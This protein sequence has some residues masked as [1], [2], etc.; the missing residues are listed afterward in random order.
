[1]GKSFRDAEKWYRRGLWAVAF[2]FGLFLTGLAN[3]IMGDL[4]QVETQPELE[5]FIEPLALRAVKDDMRK[6]ELQVR[7]A[8]DT[9]EQAKLSHQV[10]KAD[11]DLAKEQFMAWV[12]ARQAGSQPEQ[13]KEMQVRTQ[14]VANLQAMERLALA[15]VEM[16]QKL[17]L[18][19]EQ[20]KRRAQ[21][22]YRELEKGARGAHQSAVNATELRVFLYRLLFCMPLLAAAA[23]L[24][25]HQL[26]GR[27][28]PLVWGFVGFAVFVFM[29]E[30]LPH[31]PSY[32]GYVHYTLAIGLTAWLGS[33]AMGA[34]N[35]YLAEK[36][37][38][39]Q[40]PEWERRRALD[41]DLA[42]TQLANGICPGCE[43]KVDTKA[44]GLDFCPHCG[45]GLHV[46][47][48]TCNTRKSAFAR[49]CHGCG[50]TSISDGATASV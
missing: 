46:G 50:A 29:V 48:T 34:M 17:L 38:S 20:A 30:L 40:L 10:A 7:E 43:R 11:T 18:D 4:P 12:A 35:R 2:L 49:Y 45:I 22:K 8:T 6:A 32:G 16:Q 25:K 31:L 3:T 41:P 36:R 1:M 15:K 47:C 24:F 23:W 26:H 5:S 44:A 9:L 42:S 21:D 27:H 19:A 28:W 37:H 39:E 33:K 14:A 13:D